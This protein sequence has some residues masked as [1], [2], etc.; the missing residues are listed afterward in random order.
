[1]VAVS[2]PNTIG[3]YVIWENT[4]NHRIDTLDVEHAIL[5]NVL[6]QTKCAMRPYRVQGSKNSRLLFAYERLPTV[7]TLCYTCADSRLPREGA[8]L[9]GRS[10]KVLKK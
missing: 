8:V 4:E 9:V 6:G 3:Q 7:S 5:L 1:M 2:Q 10:D